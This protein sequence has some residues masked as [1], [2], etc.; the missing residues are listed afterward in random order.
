M[1]Y[2]RQVKDEDE[3]PLNPQGT[4]KGMPLPCTEQPAQPLYRELAGGKIKGR[5]LPPP[6]KTSGF[7]DKTMITSPSTH[8]VKRYLINARN[9]LRYYQ[10]PLAYMT[11]MQRTYG[12]MSSS[13]IGDTTMYA[14]FTP[15]AVRAVLIDHAHAFSNREINEPLVSFLGN[16]LLT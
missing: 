14:F 8:L 12:K 9:M 2:K 7:W 15:E 1:P 4:R 16:G 10:D 11:W 6:W 5:G 13:T 3:P